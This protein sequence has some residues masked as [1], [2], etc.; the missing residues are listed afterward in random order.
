MYDQVSQPAKAARQ[1][2]NGNPWASPD[3]GFTVF[4]IEILNPPHFHGESLSYVR[5]E[6]RE[7]WKN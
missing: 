7:A 5:S 2:P 6:G 1:M 4:N 3:L